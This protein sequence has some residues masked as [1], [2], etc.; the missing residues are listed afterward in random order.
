MPANMFER[1][2]EL[3]KSRT[4]LDAQIRETFPGMA[5]FAGTGFTRSTC[6][7]CEFYTINASKSKEIGRAHV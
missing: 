5:H 7:G 3:T 2:L 6:S 4:K 1:Q